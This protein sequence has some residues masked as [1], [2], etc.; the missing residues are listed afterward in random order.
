[1]AKIKLGSNLADIRGKLN[2]HVFSKNR[3]GNYIRNKVT[4]VNPRTAAQSAVRLAFALISSLWRAMTAANRASWINGASD[5]S[6]KN[7][8]GDT[9]ILTGLQLFQRINNNLNNVGISMLDTCP[10]NYGVESSILVSVA[11]SKTANTMSMVLSDAVGSKTKL[12]LFAT[13]GLSAGRNFVKSQL[14]Q[15][16]IVDSD[17]AT[18]VDIKAD[19]LSKYGALPEK[20]LKVFVGIVSV[21]V[22]SGVSSPMQ[23]VNHI[24]V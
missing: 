11:C 24:V 6:K 22:D 21:N 14:R 19:Y 16:G 23:I 7:V 17:A 18:P 10:V 1:M 12:K 4:P 5:F 13:P 9:N 2:G 20:G 3:N 15:I 8:F